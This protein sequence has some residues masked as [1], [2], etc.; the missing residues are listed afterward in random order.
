MSPK[1]DALFDIVSRQ[2]VAMKAISLVLFVYSRSPF[3]SVGQ[4]SGK[5]FTTGRSGRTK[6]ARQCGCPI[7]G[8]GSELADV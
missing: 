5:V 6:T 7:R 1:C 4:F 2:G 8:S 3:L